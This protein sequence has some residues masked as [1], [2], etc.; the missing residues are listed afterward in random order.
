M[1]EADKIKESI[2]Y[3]KFW[4]GILVASDIGLVTWFINNFDT[5]SLVTGI[6]AVIIF[7]LFGFGIFKLHKGIERKIDRLEAL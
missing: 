6:G 3:L 4:L 2:G 5:L 7:G 1:S